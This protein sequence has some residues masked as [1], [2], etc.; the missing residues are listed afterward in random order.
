L[1]VTCSPYDEISSQDSSDLSVGVL[2]GYDLLDRVVRLG[3]ASAFPV[4]ARVD[5]LDWT[6]SQKSGQL[7]IGS[8]L[9]AKLKKV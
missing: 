1:A 3:E 4:A 6:A 5:G 9:L 8:R 2:V 7:R